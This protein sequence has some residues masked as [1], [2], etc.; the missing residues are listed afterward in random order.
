MKK[1]LSTVFLLLLLHSLCH[2]QHIERNDVDTLTQKPIKE[3]TWEKLNDD[4][5]R[6]LE[7]RFR[8]ANDTVYLELSLYLR[9]PFKVVAKAPAFLRLD[10]S[11]KITLYCLNN[12][13]AVAATLGGHKYCN[14]HYLFALP[15]DAIQKMEAHQLAEMRLDVGDRQLVF[16]NMGN[17]R[18]AEDMQQGLKL[19]LSVPLRKKVPVKTRWR[20][21]LHHE[22]PDF[23][24]VE[25]FVK[26][27]TGVCLELH[28][29]KWK[30]EQGQRLNIYT[31]DSEKIS[32]FAADITLPRTK[33]NEDVG[34]FVRFPISREMLMA[35][36]K[37]IYTKITIQTS[38]DKIKDLGD[39]ES[40][41]SLRD[42]AEFA[43]NAFY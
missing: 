31:A 22:N 17:H 36:S 4:A 7:H 8:L 34:C 24:V 43:L 19:L 23:N 11:E 15:Q 1:T 12:E 2:A 30:L 37:K 29:L 26:N 25:R 33:N 38:T 14:A 32:L 39:N 21:L 18:R 10:D 3:T 9:T 13:Y 16:A 35:L 27:D 20:P 28:L 40:K 5:D 42:N 41:T 6:Y